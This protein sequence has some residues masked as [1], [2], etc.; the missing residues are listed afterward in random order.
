M[1]L[2]L[3]LYYIEGY[4]LHL[5]LLHHA[6]VRLVYIVVLQYIL[7]SSFWS[8]LSA[9]LFSL[10]RERGKRKEE[11]EKSSKCHK[12]RFRFLSPA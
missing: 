1:L 8:A 2:H 7:F 4:L 3:G 10:S 5:G 6:L 12:T 9:V 11:A